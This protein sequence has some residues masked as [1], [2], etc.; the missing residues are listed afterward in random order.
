MTLHATNGLQSA[1]NP[2]GTGLALPAGSTTGSTT[3]NPPTSALIQA[4]LDFLRAFSTLSPEIVISH[5]IPEFTHSVSPESLSLPS[6]GLDDFQTH[7][8]RVFSL[9][10]TWNIVPQTVFEDAAKN[11]VVLH[12][13]MGGKV[14][15]NA[16]GDVEVWENEAVFW[17]E[18]GQHEDRWAV[19]SFREFVDS[20]LAEKLRGLLAGTA[21]QWTLEE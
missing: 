18:L 11:T 14:R 12:V 20:K 4:A 16:L 19:K 7:S 9:F 17:V 1:A 8:R 10:T 5:C 3:S 6:R 2:S 13:K 21:K 15:E